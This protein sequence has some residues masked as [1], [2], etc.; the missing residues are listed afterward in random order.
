VVGYT[1]VPT[2]LRFNP[3]KGETM[4]TPTRE[5]RT[6]ATALA[7]DIIAGTLVRPDEPVQIPNKDEAGHV[8]FALASY[9]GILLLHSK[10]DGIT[11]TDLAEG[12]RSAAEMLR[13]S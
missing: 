11:G 1:A 13:A 8:I 7:M 10:D 5:E 9:A 3:V 12:L 6:A 4:S 2:T